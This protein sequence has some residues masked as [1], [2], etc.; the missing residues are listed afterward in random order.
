MKTEP[1]VEELKRGDKNSGQE[2]F[3][4]ALRWLLQYV[5]LSK[6]SFVRNEIDGCL[7]ARIKCTRMSDVSRQ[8]K[9]VGW[10]L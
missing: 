8:K 1:G 2:I 6:T 9:L 5:V 7:L 4:Q 10:N 3:R